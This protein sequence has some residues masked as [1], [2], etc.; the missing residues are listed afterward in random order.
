MNHGLQMGSYSK[1]WRINHEEISM[2][3]WSLWMGISITLF[4]IVLSVVF[5]YNIGSRLGLKMGSLGSSLFLTS[6]G[7]RPDFFWSLTSERDS[8]EKCRSRLE[9]ATK[10]CKMTTFQKR[11]IFKTSTQRERSDDG[12]LRD[13]KHQCT[14]YNQEFD[15]TA[16]EFDQSESFKKVTWLMWLV[17]ST[18]EF[19]L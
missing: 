3:Q 5:F 4:A 6:C 14:G 8:E 10:N 13:V 17:N 7:R 16:L 15:S 2:Y 19:C 1:L 18:I 11:Q 12:V 9:K